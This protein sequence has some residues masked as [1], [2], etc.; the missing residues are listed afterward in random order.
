MPT[1]LRSNEPSGQNEKRI[2]DDP[3]RSDP[4]LVRQIVERRPNYEQLVDEIVYTL[5]K[6]IKEAD[7]EVSSVTGR[8]KTLK[9]FLE[10]LQRK[11]YKSPLEE[12]TD[13]AGVRVVCL[14]REDVRTIEAIVRKEFEVLEKV[15]KDAEK[16]ADQFGYGAVHFVVKLG[17]K[18]S[19]A[20][21]DDL[22]LLRCEIQVRTIMQDAW[23]TI[24]H[25]LIYK[26]E[27]EVPKPLQRRLNSLAGLFETADDQFARI[28]QDR[29]DYLA[30]VENSSSNKDVF[31]ETELNLDTIQK[32]L[33]WKFPKRPVERFRGQLRR[34]FSA[35][36]LN[37]Y[38]ILRSIDEAINATEKTRAKIP[39]HLRTLKRTAPS[40]VIP[41]AVEMA[42]A[43]SIVDKKFRK[44][45]AMPTDW[46]E[47]IMTS[48]KE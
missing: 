25:H 5:K 45:P 14:Y 34:I 27:S 8:A 13:L 46:L 37:T 44:R 36:D 31:L 39:K 24:Q 2:E 38:P 26:R 18:S 17:K 29:D 11:E 15:D 4:D 23:A 43:L 10:K 16:T 30:T 47:A 3:W 6:R 12:V 33:E 32:Y 48:M 21:Y 1:A 20:R 35:I 7:I 41:A 19:G 42:W 9:S 22:K 28:R 40:G